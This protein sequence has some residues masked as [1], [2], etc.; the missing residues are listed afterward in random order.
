MR[1]FLICTT[2]LVLPGVIGGCRKEDE[3]PP[4]APPSAAVAYP[5]PETRPQPTDGR[6]A[7]S[8]PVSAS[9]KPTPPVA[10]KPPPPVPMPAAGAPG[11]MAVPGNLASPCQNDVPCGTHRCNVTY[12][13][14]AFP[15]QTNVDCLAPNACTTGFCV[16]APVAQPQK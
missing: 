1:M 9:Q 11:Q 3:T 7:A 2:A 12:G 13:K 8:G 4:S 10:T 16:P 14:C 6:N 15:C 5:A